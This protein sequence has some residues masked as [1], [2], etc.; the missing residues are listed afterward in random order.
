MNAVERV[1]AN[2]LESVEV[3]ETSRGGYRLGLI[4]YD[5]EVILPL[6]SV[7]TGDYGQYRARNA[8]RRFLEGE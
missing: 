4:R 5:G 6:G 7:Y 2:D 1:A 8:V 3:Q